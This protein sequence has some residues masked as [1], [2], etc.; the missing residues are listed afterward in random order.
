MNGTVIQR[1]GLSNAEAS[2]VV[3]PHLS[4]RGTNC[5]KRKY[6]PEGQWED[7]EQLRSICAC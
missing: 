2:A 7:S 5:D 1:L 3:A 4:R 6:G